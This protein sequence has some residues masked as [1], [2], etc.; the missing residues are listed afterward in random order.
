MKKL[1]AILAVMAGLT[2]MAETRPIPSWGEDDIEKRDIG[3]GL[4]VLVSDTKAVLGKSAALYHAYEAIQNEQRFKAGTAILAYKFIS[5]EPSISYH[6]S[7]PNN[8]VDFEFVFPIRWE[9]I[10]LDLAG[11]REVGDLFTRPKLG[12]WFDSIYARPYL[13][14]NV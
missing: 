7:A 3:W 14:Q 6:P 5:I 9:H 2:G 8:V 11:T 10:P 4:N 1:I 12:G 13:T